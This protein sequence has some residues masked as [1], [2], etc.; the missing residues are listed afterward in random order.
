[1][2]VAAAFGAALLVVIGSI[3]GW[4]SFHYRT[5]L[6]TRSV[7]LWS[8]LLL[9]LLL[10]GFALPLAFSLRRLPVTGPT[11]ERAGLE[12]TTLDPIKITHPRP[13]GLLTDGQPM[14]AAATGF[15][16]EAL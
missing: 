8:L 11:T 3:A 6:L 14:G 10:I 7:P 12:P 1:V 16:F 2:S 5:G 15:L 9:T 13:G 4:L